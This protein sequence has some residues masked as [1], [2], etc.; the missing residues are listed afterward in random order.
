MNLFT[1][2]S[3]LKIVTPI[4]FFLVNINNGHAQLIDT[5][6]NVGGHHLHFNIIKGKGS[7]ILFESGGNSDA[8]EWDGI[9]K[10]LKNSIDATLIAYDRA[11][12][13][14]SEMDTSKTGVLNEVKSLEIALNKLGY[15]NNLMVVAFSLGG[16]YATLFTS[17]NP[18]LVKSCVFIDIALPCFMTKETARRIKESLPDFDKEL[19]KGNYYV[20]LN[21]E[22]MHDLL[23]QTIFPESIPVTVISSEIPPF[24]GLDSIR[25]KSCQQSFGMLPNHTY[26]LAKNCTHMQCQVYPATLDEIIKMYRRRKRTS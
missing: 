25:W 26:L 11:G 24:D 10:N 20:R 16:S 21:F 23:R 8:Q 3:I 18:A 13:G 6:I 17:R 15:T 2:R 7:P 1:I 22:K 14:T 4:L 12:R 19:D 9:R 5:L